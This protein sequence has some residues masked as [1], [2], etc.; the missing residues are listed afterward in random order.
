MK[1]ILLDDVKKVGKKGEVV[2]V[3]FG[4]ARNFLF[5]RKLA[6]LADAGSI[7]LFK[8]RIGLDEQ[9]TKN[10]NKQAEKLVAKLAG[11]IFKIHRPSDSKGNLY[12]GLKELEILAKIKSYANE[13]PFQSKIADYSVIKKSG[14][15]KIKLQMTAGD[16]CEIIIDVNLP[17]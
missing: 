3:S 10:R 4:Y 14:S 2:E 15:H 12:A 5:P 8:N 16:S 13:L 11:R 7:A 1:I 17:S 6:H 9:E